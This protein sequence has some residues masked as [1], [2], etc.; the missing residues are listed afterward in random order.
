MFDPKVMTVI[1][2]SLAAKIIQAMKQFASL[3][4]QAKKSLELG[5]HK[6]FAELMSAN[7]NLRRATYGDAVIGASNLRMIQLAQ[8]HNCVAK[9]PGS[10]GAVVGMWHGENKEEEKKDLFQLCRALESE[11]YVFIELSPMIYE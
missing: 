1:N 5:D 3:T 8:E 6:R 11:G 9:F 10:G 4:D 2:L 7:F